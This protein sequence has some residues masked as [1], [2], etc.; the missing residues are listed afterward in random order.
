MYISSIWSLQGGTWINTFS[1]DTPT[2]PRPEIF[3][4]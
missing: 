1:Q 4:S 2:E 3:G